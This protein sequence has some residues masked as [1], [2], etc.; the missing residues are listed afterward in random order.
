[1][2]GGGAAF[3]SALNAPGWATA[4][5]VTGSIVTA[6]MRSVLSVMPPSTA[7]EPPDRLDPAPRGTTGTRWAARPPQHRLHVGVELARTTASG[8]PASGSRA[9]SCR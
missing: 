5:R 2:L 1:M 7:V 6:R 3:T 8:R 9:Q 4:T